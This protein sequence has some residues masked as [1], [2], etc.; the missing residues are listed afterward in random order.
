M[1]DLDTLKAKYAELG[2]EIE[3]LEAAKKEPQRWV[4]E[5]GETYFFVG[6][7][8]NTLKTGND[9]Y[10]GDLKLIDF[11]NCWPTEE[12][13]KK[14]AI[15]IKILNIMHAHADGGYFSVSPV[16][17]KVLTSLGTYGI[18][19]HYSTV[20]RAEFVSALVRPLFKELEE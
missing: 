17:G 18:A 16:T 7:E 8:G 20:E 4:P 19:A 1:N 6:T 10:D 12:A 5:T 9:K 3:R 11:H 2:K 13:V 15:R 14:Q